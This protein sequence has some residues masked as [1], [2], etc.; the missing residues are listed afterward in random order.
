MN[1]PRRADY[2]IDAPMVLRRFLVLGL[3]G[4]T[5]AAFLCFFGV[6]WLRPSLA[7]SIAISL[8]SSGLSLIVCGGAMLWGSKV[9]KLRLA[10]RLV[11]G[12]GL[13][14]D[15]LVL[16]VG[17][18]HGLMLVAAAK[19]LSQGKA[20]GIDLWQTEDQAG[21]SAEATLA[22][23]HL[24]GV[25]SRVELR[26]GD[27]REL[28]FGQN[29]VD[30]VVSSWALHN[31]YD[32]AGRERAIR[33]IARVLKPGGR[34]GIIDI[35]HAEEYAD[36]LRSLDFEVERRGKSFVFVIPSQSFI[37]KKRAPNQ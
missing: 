37:A 16:D 13:R 34:A 21:N 10:A 3:A 19:K 22:N 15:E 11:E 33:E 32:R 25:A 2:G 1:A 18:G 36:L 23:A 35:R 28:P 27:A 30:V 31:I 29:A 7:I 9:G 20:I 12:L 6:R 8:L 17:C 14:G 5:G 4:L 24:E 26:T